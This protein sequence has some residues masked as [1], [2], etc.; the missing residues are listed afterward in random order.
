MGICHAGRGGGEVNFKETPPR[1][2]GHMYGSYLAFKSLFMAVI[3]P[4]GE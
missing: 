4:D 2:Q 1:K 3:L